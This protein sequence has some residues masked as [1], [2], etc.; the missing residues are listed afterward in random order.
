MAKKAYVHLN[1]VDYELAYPMEEQQ[2]QQLAEKIKPKSAPKAGEPARPFEQVGDPVQVLD[3]LINGE[4]ASLT[5]RLDR[6]WASAAS[7]AKT[8]GEAWTAPVEE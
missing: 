1:G 8:R 3:V 5:V 7:L 4:R 2:L 6:L